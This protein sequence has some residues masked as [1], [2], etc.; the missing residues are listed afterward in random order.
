[1]NKKTD[2]DILLEY[3]PAFTVWY[4]LIILYLIQ[5]IIFILVMVF[6]WWISSIIFIG[7]ILGQSIVSIL[8]A[9]YFISMVNN[10]KKIREK[11]RKKYDELAVQHFW[12]NYL[13]YINPIVSATFYFPIL[14]KT[15]YFLPA[16]V[17]FPSHFITISMFPYYVAFPIG[18]TLVIVGLLM[19][20]FSGGYGIDTDAYLY[21]IYPEKGRL[22]TDGMYKY[23]RNPQYLCRGIIAIGFGFIANNIIAVS[24]GFIHFLSYLAIIPTEDKELIKRFG[25]DFE[26]YQKNVPAVLP[27]YGNWKKFIKFIFIGENVEMRNKL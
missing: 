19:R 14:L 8:L 23:I 22:I 9:F 6:F 2:I 1:M 7:A 26:S 20:R 12:Y 3:I 10:S 21:M 11:Y 17:S 18:I 16:I 15:D 25:T 24:V 13:A 27:K 4:K 5:F